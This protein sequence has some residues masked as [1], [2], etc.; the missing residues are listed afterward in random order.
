M[1]EEQKIKEVEKDEYAEAPEKVLDKSDLEE[2]K[3]LEKE[4]GEK[5]EVEKPRGRRGEPTREEIIEAWDPKTAGRP[6]TLQ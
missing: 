6:A 4:N 2:L 1:A 5:K 3:K